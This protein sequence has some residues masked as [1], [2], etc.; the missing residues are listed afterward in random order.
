MQ[1]STKGIILYRLSHLLHPRH[2]LKYRH[3]GLKDRLR[4]GEKATL[5]ITVRNTN[6]DA[7]EGFTMITEGAVSHFNNWALEFGNIAS[8]ATKTRALGFS[9]DEMSPQNVSVRLRFE[10][11]NN[12]THPEIEKIL[13]IIE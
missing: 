7:L 11:A 9:T 3:C 1:N 5:K 12:F 6:K 13:R 2:K 4:V 10:A 8:G